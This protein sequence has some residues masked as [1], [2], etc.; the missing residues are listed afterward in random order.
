MLFP[1]RIKAAKLQS[2]LREVTEDG[3]VAGGAGAAGGSAGAGCSGVAG[4]AGGAGA[5][6]AGGVAGS[7]TSGSGEAFLNAAVTPLGALVN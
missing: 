1:N 7:S 2:R 5:G 6:A 4:A 3:T